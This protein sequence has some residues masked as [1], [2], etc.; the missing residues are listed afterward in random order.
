MIL[1]YLVR[2]L[3]T[4]GN[5]TVLFE[6]RS[7][8]PEKLPDSLYELL[9]ISFAD[10][11]SLYFEVSNIMWFSSSTPPSGS[12]TA[13]AH[14]EMTNT[15]AASAAVILKNFF[16]NVHSLTS[17]PRISIFALF[18]KNQKISGI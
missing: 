10:K 13:K 15:D 16:N 7:Q 4:F 18:C 6:Y 11:I 3:G 17:H 9:G 8:Q 1:S 14:D 5:C 12:L 2:S